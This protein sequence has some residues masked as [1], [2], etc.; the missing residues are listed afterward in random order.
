MV[1]AE[2]DVDGHVSLRTRRWEQLAVD[3]TEVF[4]IHEETV[5]PLSAL[6][7]EVRVDEHGARRPKVL[8][9]AA[10][11]VLPVLGREIVLEREGRGEPDHGVVVVVYGRAA[12]VAGGDEDLARGVIDDDAARGPDSVLHAASR[13]NRW[14]SGAAGRHRD[15]VPVIRRPVVRAVTI[16]A[17]EWDIDVPV[18]E[19]QGSALLLDLPVESSDA[20]RS[21]QN[22][23]S[24]SGQVQPEDPIDISVEKRGHVDPIGRGV[25]DRCAEDALRRNVAAD[26]AGRLRRAEMLR[27]DHGAVGLVQRVDGVVQRPDVDDSLEDERLCIDGFVESG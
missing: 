24:R 1:V 18:G 23:S 25:D 13:V 27:P 8:I 10:P 2:T 4:G 14:R 19:R 6:P 5:A 20:E 9:V 11:V 26:P 16:P 21:L 3:A 15:D 22:H 12:S 17:A 7:G